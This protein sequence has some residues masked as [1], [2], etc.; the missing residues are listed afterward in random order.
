[1]VT[2]IVS[3]LTFVIGVAAGYFL[4]KF[5][6]KGREKDGT[7]Y[8]DCSDPDR[9]VYRFD[10]EDIGKLSRQKTIILDVNYNG[11]FTQN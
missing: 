8:I 4:F 1:M 3:L 9:D 6:T 10:I 5:L 11:D 7:L 2:F